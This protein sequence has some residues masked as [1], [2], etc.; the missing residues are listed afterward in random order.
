MKDGGMMLQRS[1]VLV[2]ILLTLMM[3]ACATSYDTVSSTQGGYGFYV[4]EMSPKVWKISFKGNDAN[5]LD[6][7]KEYT[8]RKAAE[9]TLQEKCRFFTVS[10]SSSAKDSS[11]NMFA[12][13]VSGDVDVKQSVETITMVHLFKEKP[14]NK[15]EV[16]DAQ[17]LV[18]KYAAKP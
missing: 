9:I 13:V 3:A 7:T 4:Q 5:S 8:L 2:L 12:F 18:A 14:K 17:F 15:D 6:Q 1:K 16:F 10:S 11:V